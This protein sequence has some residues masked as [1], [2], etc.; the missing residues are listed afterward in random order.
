MLTDQRGQRSP[1]LATTVDY[2][3]AR[4][5]VGQEGGVMSTPSS[6]PRRGR[7]PQ[8]AAVTIAGLVV[9]VMSHL[10]QPIP[11]GAA[12]MQM[13]VCSH[14]GTQTYNILGSNAASLRA[15]LD[16]PANFGPA[17]SYGDYD[18]EYVDLGDG[19]TEQM[20]LDA[21]CDIYFSGFESDGSYTE[22]E[23]QAIDD[24]IAHDPTRQVVAG[25]DGSANDPVCDRLGFTVTTDT[26]TYGFLADLEVN[27]INCDETIELTDQIN[28]AGGIGGYF[29]GPAVTAAN[30]AAIHETSGSP[31]PAKPIV[32]YTG[33]FFFTS[34]INMIETGGTELTMSDGDGV[35]TINDILAMN[36]FSG[37]ADVAA[38]L[39]LC[40]SAAPPA[41]PAP[42][43]PPASPNPA[44][45]AARTVAVQPTF[46]G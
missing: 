43:A 16:N 34:D 11:A 1:L 7:R 45:P 27:P 31:D 32:I 3:R 37:L 9:L 14:Q 24:W 4:R 17:G 39:S 26:D 5:F 29:S 20:L 6:H 35:T 21:S 44:A 15:K 23:L 36:A 46:T 30:T 18:F 12:T 19:L 28:M 40:S 42:S 25:C 2:G 8:I 41:P 38:G 10:V 33:N 13:T 22:A